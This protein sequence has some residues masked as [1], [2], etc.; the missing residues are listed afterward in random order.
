MPSINLTRLAN[1]LNEVYVPKSMLTNGLIALFKWLVAELP[2]MGERIPNEEAFLEW[3]QTGFQQRARGY[4]VG[5]RKRD[6]IVGVIVDL[7]R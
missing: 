4:R 2:K 3:I 6:W 7:L 5:E 1:R